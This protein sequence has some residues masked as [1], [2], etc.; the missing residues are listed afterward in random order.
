MGA[1]IASM[2]A[3]CF[4]KNINKLIL[5]DM[6]GPLNRAIT[7]TTT[8]LT[9]SIL[10]ISTKNPSKTLYP[11]IE[12]MI[13]RSI[14]KS[15]LPADLMAPMVKHGTIAVTG[16]Y[17]WTFDSRLLLPS[18]TCLSEPR[19]LNLLSNITCPN[20]T[21]MSEKIRMHHS[22]QFE[23]RYNILHH[24]TLATVNAGL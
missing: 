22:T 9:Q 21:I 19:I 12:S 11:D 3:A 1:A 18:S 7:D 8:K 20:L 5:L 15:G 16:G 24:N 4:P 10:A 17:Q 13:K 6:L 14:E 2:Y 23:A